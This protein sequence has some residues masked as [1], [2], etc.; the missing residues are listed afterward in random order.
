MKIAV[1]KL[2]CTLTL[3]AMSLT[4]GSGASIRSAAIE[5]SVAI[6]DPDVLHTLGTSGLGLAR[7][8]G[9]DANSSAASLFALPS[10]TTVRDATDHDFSRYV[11][12]HKDAPDR[13]SLFDRDALN[14]PGTRFDLAGIVNRMDRA[15]VSPGECGE[16]RLI[17]RPIANRGS[18][19]RAAPPSRLPMTFNLVMKA[20]PAS[21]EVTCAELA[22][23]WLALGE[24]SLAGTERA[25]MLT[26]RG[27]ALEWVTPEAIDRIELNIQVAREAASANDFDGRADYLM[28]VFRL[29][30]QRKSFEES[31]LENQ[32]DIERLRTDAK[33]AADFKQWLLE[34]SHVADLD[35]GTIVLPDRFL[36]THAI[37]ETPGHE[38]YESRAHDLFPDDDVVAALA[39]MSADKASAKA[40]L[41]NILSPAGFARR[42]D[43]MTCGG[44][45]Q[46]RAIGGFHFPGKERFAP[47]SD[48]AVVAAASPHFFGDQER[49]RDI[50]SAFRDGAPPDFSR[51]F[52]A[53]PQPRRAGELAG[54]TYVDGWGAVCSLPDTSAA[55]D[56]SFASWTCAEG[57]T[58]QAASGVKD[59]RAGFCFPK[60]N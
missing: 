5:R 29:D 16:I 55:P 7:M 13:L 2:L 3:L 43:D 60:S 25:P 42:L 52:S 51:G 59:S 57:L 39:R 1:Q 33:L 15:Y 34:P 32:I 18:A 38:A 9:A 54:T 23:R 56:R 30:P 8:L 49:R 35:R 22:K 26:A 36:A 12:D 21:A 45:H 10:M 28:K 24:L 14:A 37:N 47:V 6:T 19:S 11:V 46:T 20:K 17:Y 58:C 44:C 31:P 27:G 50:L 41:R 53:R 4:A 40:P 48:S